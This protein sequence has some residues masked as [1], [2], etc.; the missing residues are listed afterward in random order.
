[1]P[2]RFRFRL[3]A[4]RKVRRQAQ[5]AQQRVVAGVLREIRQTEAGVRQLTEEL[6][7]EVGATRAA[8]SIQRLDLPRIR[9]HQFRQTW[10]QGRVLDAQTE[11]GR[12]QTRLEQE[13]AK[14]AE[15]ARRLKVIE[16]L[17]ER[18]W[19]RFCIEERRAEQRENDEV[20]NQLHLRRAPDTHLAAM[21]V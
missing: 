20:A 16:K 5:D 8:Q 6:R 14:L 19:E 10:L 11:L 12:L 17:R 7:A 13:R 4:V 2:G 15:A 9:G 3:E 1:M 21:G 18:Q